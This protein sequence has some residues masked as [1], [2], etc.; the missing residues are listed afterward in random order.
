M[1]ILFVAGFWPYCPRSGAEP[2]PVRRHVQDTVQRRRGGYLHTDALAGVKHFALSRGY[3]LLVA[4]RKEPWG[5][6][7]TRFQEPEGLL[8]GVTHT[9]WMREDNPV[10]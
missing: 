6:V 1:K 5:Q 4:A 8:V 7:V 10:R 2:R 9:P 3:L